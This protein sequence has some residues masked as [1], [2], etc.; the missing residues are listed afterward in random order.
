MKRGGGTKPRKGSGWHT[1]LPGR[2]DSTGLPQI[3][4]SIKAA[5]ENGRVHVIMRGGRMRGG[6]GL[7]DRPEPG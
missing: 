7:G 5:E 2:V 3:D 1:D 6:P 4:S